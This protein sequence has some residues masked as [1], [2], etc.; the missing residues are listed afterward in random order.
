MNE[1]VGIVS[2]GTAL[3]H[4]ALK[5]SVLA[6]AQRRENLGKSLG[7]AQKTVPTGDEDTI[8]LATSA[9]HQA[10]ER[11]PQSVG[12]EKIGT[13]FIGSESHPYAVKPSGTV[14]SAALGLSSV[15]SMADLQFACKAGT[16]SLQAAMV[17]AQ[18]GQVEYGLAIG[19]DTAQARPGDVLEY[20]AAA[21]AAAH[22]LGRENIVAELLGTASYATDTPDFWR[23]P[24]Q[25]H[26][27]HAGRFTGD[28]AYF[29]HIRSAT[30]LLL[31]KVEMK[32]SDFD[33]CVFHTPNGRFPVQ[34]A[35]QLGC[36]SEQL[37]WSLPVEKI[38][39]TYAAASMLALASV[40][41]HARANQTIL[42][43]SYGSGAG[44]DSFAFRTTKELVQRR[45]EWRMFVQDRVKALDSSTSYE[46]Y[47]AWQEARCE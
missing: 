4:F 10:L 20:T 33:W 28:P 11:L 7:I 42:I 25:S 8:T 2:Y 45:K 26:P 32:V 43:T 39:N 30:A 13:L 46:Q 36:T 38:G 41:D 16:Q 27:E 5:T 29:H 35:K 23:R 24:G 12:K 19:A 21:G 31:T 17:Y 9:A 44:A 6:Q 34:V 1:R 15:M 37:R 14:V 3:P 18:A 40:L 47:R 22:V